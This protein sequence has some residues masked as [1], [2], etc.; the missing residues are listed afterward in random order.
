MNKYGSFPMFHNVS[1]AHVAH[2]NSKNNPYADTLED[3]AGYKAT[4]ISTLSFSVCS[5]CESYDTCLQ[6]IK[7][8]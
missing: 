2:T 6:Q 1:F 5:F 4:Y 8:I 3:I 7:L